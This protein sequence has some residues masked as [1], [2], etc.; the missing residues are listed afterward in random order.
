[1]FQHQTNTGIRDNHHQHH[2]NNNNDKNI[3]VGSPTRLTRTLSYNDF[4]NTANLPMNFWFDT[5][6]M[7]KDDQLTPVEDTSE[8]RHISKY[9]GTGEVHSSF[10][11]SSRCDQ[12][13][14]RMLL[15]HVYSKVK[16]KPA[17]ESS[18]PSGRS[19]SRFP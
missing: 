7:M 8:N 12:H 10:Y 1:M 13:P 19:L 14:A 3:R 6:N 4:Q 16:V 18:G 9:K 5:Q 2:H 17:Y 11:F 15:I